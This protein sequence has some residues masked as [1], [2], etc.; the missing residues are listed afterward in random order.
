M[1]DDTSDQSRKHISDGEIKSRIDLEENQKLP[2]HFNCFW[3][4]SRK[5]YD[6]RVQNFAKL[7]YFYD[8]TTRFQKEQSPIF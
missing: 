2:S 4:W 7:K 3:F 6:I 5:E 8:K 1:T